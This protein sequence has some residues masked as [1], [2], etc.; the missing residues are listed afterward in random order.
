M[1]NEENCLTKRRT[2]CGDPVNFRQTSRYQVSY[3]GKAMEDQHQF[4]LLE[5]HEYSDG[6]V[7]EADWEEAPF[8]HL[9][10]VIQVTEAGSAQTTRCSRS[11]RGFYYP[12]GFPFSYSH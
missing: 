11:R 12:E 3:D 10:M 5:L 9:C 4:T 2:A 1:I 6:A 8:A 7:R